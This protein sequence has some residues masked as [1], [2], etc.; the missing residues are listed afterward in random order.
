MNVF[1]L[2]ELKQCKESF[3]GSSVQ[4][5][6]LEDWKGYGEEA[7]TDMTVSEVAKAIISLINWLQRKED[8]QIQQFNAKY[9]HVGDLCFY[10]CGL[11]FP[12]EAGYQRAGLILNQ[13]GDVVL[14]VPM[15]CSQA[16]H[17]EATLY[18][19][20]SYFL[21]DPCFLQEKQMNPNT[22]LLMNNIQYISVSRII[23]LIDHIDPA[24]KEFLRV[25]DQLVQNVL[26]KKQNEK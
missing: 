4:E 10:D 7:F 8:Y 6:L 14:M 15:T 5:D 13:L 22:V 17:E 19:D 21:L 3:V 1:E 20:G 24:S 12:K 25:R 11:P 9:Y 16:I 2:N 18:P 26:S 23:K